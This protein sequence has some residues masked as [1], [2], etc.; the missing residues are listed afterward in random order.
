MSV[1]PSVSV[2]MA[3]FNG[4]PYLQD[5]LDSLFTQTLRDFEVIV[6]DDASTDGSWEL[7]TSMMKSNPRIRGFRNP[8]NQGLAGSLNRGL[9]EC[10][11]QLIARADADDV[12]KPGRLTAQVAYLREHPEVGVLGTAVSFIDSHGNPIARKLNFFP[13]THEQILLQSLLGC[14]LWHTT[15]MFR[16]AVVDSVGGYDLA[17][18]KGPEDYDLWSRLLEK[19]EFANLADPLASQRLHESSIT[20]TWN[21]GF[22]MYCEVSRKLV[23][24][25]LGRSVTEEEATAAVTLSGWERRMERDSCLLGVRILQEIR[26]LSM[27]RVQKSVMHAF[28]KKIAQAFRRQASISVYSDPKLSRILLFESLRWDS[29]GFLSVSGLVICSKAFLPKRLILFLKSLFRHF[30]SGNTTIP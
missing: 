14:C 26:T 19:T 24:N 3:V 21:S 15:V 12:F 28:E 6:V 20:A 17:Y 18:T 8:V 4:L 5:A 10:R 11:A 13:I 1:Q 23:S 7:V 25:W 29:S 22:Q 27:N 2:L 9:A 16:K 30:H